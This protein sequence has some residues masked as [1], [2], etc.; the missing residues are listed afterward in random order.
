MAP[1]AFLIR[2]AR[3]LLPFDL[4]IICSAFVICGS[5]SLFAGP[6]PLQWLKLPVPPFPGGVAEIHSITTVSQENLILGT[7]P[8]TALLKVKSSGDAQWHWGLAD[9]D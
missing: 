5:T 4:S 1:P 9:N 6:P 8:K 3:R 2:S 7:V